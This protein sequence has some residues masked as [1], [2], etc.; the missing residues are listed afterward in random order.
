MIYIFI[1]A[2]I[3]II[4]VVI[5]T[6]K[7]AER[8]EE[9]ELK[10]K[11]ISF[12]DCTCSFFPSGTNALLINKAYKEAQLRGK[13][14]NFVPI[15]VVVEENLYESFL[16]NSN[17]DADVLCMEKVRKF[18]TEV[19]DKSLESG[20]ELLDERLCQLREDMEDAGD[21]DFD[22]EE[23]DAIGEAVNGFYNIQETNSLILAEIPV[24]NAWEVF[25]WLPFGGW[26]ECPDE[27]ELMSVAKYWYECYKAVPATMS[28]DVLEFCVPCPVHKEECRQLAFEQ[29][30]FCPD[31]V[32]QGVGSVKAL[33][34]M[35]SKSTV[36]F[37]WWD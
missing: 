27:I 26:N 28:S 33:E 30:A 25:A 37:F 24:R 10:D 29:Y 17:E 14:E 22:K 15:L 34:K 1:V 7:G 31:I 23:E 20:K 13:K 8:K 4:A 32:D 5:K 18:R 3:V 6:K 11:I 36:W 21:D 9:N 35:L 16:A 19:L 12:L 2:I